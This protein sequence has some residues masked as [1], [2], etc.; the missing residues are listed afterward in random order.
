MKSIIDI[1][2]FSVEEVNELLEVASDIS[3]HPKKYAKKCHGKKLATLFFE[4]STRTRLSFLLYLKVLKL[5][6][7]EHIYHLKLV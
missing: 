3:K 4:P 1:V 5:M 7:Y 2:D 6:P